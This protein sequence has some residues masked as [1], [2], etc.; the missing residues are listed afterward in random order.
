MF[1]IK[2]L[3]VR[4][5]IDHLLQFYNKYYDLLTSSLIKNHFETDPLENIL[6]VPNGNSIGKQCFPLFNLT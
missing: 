2:K 5:G 1:R 4:C 6:Q 3:S